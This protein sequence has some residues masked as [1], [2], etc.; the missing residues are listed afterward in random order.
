MKQHEQVALNQESVHEVHEGR[1]ESRTLM[2]RDGA[3]DARG[4]VPRKW[5]CSQ[6]SNGV[7]PSCL[8]ITENGWKPSKAGVGGSVRK[9]QQEK[10]TRPV[11]RE[12]REI[13]GRLLKEVEAHKAREREGKGLCVLIPRCAVSGDQSPRHNQL[14][15]R[16]QG[17]ALQ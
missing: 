4:H 11:V 1:E 10:T 7:P 2:W 9:L 8:R 12:I 6:S 13:D 15:C 14:N 5:Q 16:V 17:Q 3:E